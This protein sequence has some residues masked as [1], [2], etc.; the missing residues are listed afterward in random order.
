[1]S[2]IPQTLGPVEK[3]QYL[4]QAAAI[5]YLSR[6]QVAVRHKEAAK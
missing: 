2:D 5:P 4:A 6:V 3:L 1:M